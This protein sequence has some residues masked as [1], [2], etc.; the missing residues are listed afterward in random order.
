M[1]TAITFMLSACN[2]NEK[3]AGATKITDVPATSKSK[4]AIALF[5]EGMTLADDGSRQKARASFSRAIQLDPNM[6]I[7]YL[8][9]A[10]LS[11]SPK[12]Y[13]DELQ[14]A[15]AHLEG[16]SEWEKLFYEYQNTY[17]TNDWNKRLE[18][19]NKLATA[20]PDAARAQIHL[21]TTYQ[22]GNRVSEER[23]AFQKAT[24]LDPKWTVGYFSLAGSYLFGEPK[25]FKKAETNALKAVELTPTSSSSQILLGDVY[26]AQDD[27]EKAKTAYSKAIEL[28]PEL[29]DAYY[30]KGHVN[31]FLGKL[32][33]ARKD[34]MD[35]AKRDDDNVNSMMLIGY[36]Y[37]YADDAPRAISYFIDNANK[38]DASNSSKSKIAIYKMNYL[39]AGALASFHTGDAAH[40]REAV[41]LMQGPAD[42]IAGD[43]GAEEKSLQKANLLYWAGLADA[44]EGKLND[45][46]AKAGEIKATVASLNIPTKLENCEMLLG[47]IDYKEKKYAEAVAHFEKA[48]PFSPYSRYWVAMAHEAA[49]HKDQAMELYKQIAVYN[50][51]GPDY[52]VIRNEVKKKLT[53]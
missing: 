24:E 8:Y 33:E 16:A 46:K 14:S 11:L 42:Q 44:L 30:K 5:E 23:A 49:G 25:D 6:A 2:N 47:Y 31:S 53:M 10:N 32:D 48:S 35:G 18:V 51:N 34:Y 3:T 27:L 12:E 19:C 28:N 38:S 29:P 7:A 9:R 39:N 50:F 36:T 20:Y 52:A 41:M 26:R 4:E 40:L 21:G 22:E 13:V 1:V 15:K 43:V 17:I 37:L 45:A